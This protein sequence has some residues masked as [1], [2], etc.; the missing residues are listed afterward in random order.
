MREFA[1]KLQDPDRV[2]TVAFG[3]AT[4]EQELSCR[5]LAAAEWSMPLNKEDYVEQG[6]YLSQKPLV[7]NKGWRLWCLYLLDHPG[8][9]LATCK[10][11][12]RELLIRDVSGL[13][14]AKAY[15]IAS[16]VAHP[17][18]RGL[19]LASRLLE[20][21]KVWLDGP[22]DAAASMLYT[23]IGDFYERRDWAKLPAI[24]STLSW[25]ADFSP[26]THRAGPPVT[27]LIL[28]TELPELCRQDMRDVE[29]YF[30]KLTVQPDEFHVS[31]LPTADL[32]S[33]LH[34][35]SNF[36]GAK[37]EPAPPRSHGS[38]C[39]GADIWLYWYHDFRK[40]QL[41]VQRVRIQQA[42]SQIH[43]E[44][45]A[46][47]LMDAVEEACRWKLTKVVLWEPHAELFGAMHILQEKFNIKSETFARHNK[48]IPSLRWH[49]D[50][51]RS[52]TF[53]FNEFYT[54]S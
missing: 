26:W 5:H 31:V 8:E 48:S 39:D 54:W 35:R 44:A 30:D 49:T 19:G 51:E 33:W 12:P 27:R 10:T 3:E 16:V 13:S 46:A 25:T 40:Q 22:G 52:T 34:D 17:Q 2:L 20:Y 24:Q 18:Y 7:K 32:I 42:P 15:C 45:L 37:I 1:I 36:I 9:V 50:R 23:S 14:R 6:I 53:H 21:V 11:I 29:N 41:A 43:H 4:P 28:S 47:M 38:I